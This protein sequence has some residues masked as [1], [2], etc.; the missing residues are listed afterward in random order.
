[1]HCDTDAATAIFAANRANA[2]ARIRYTPGEPLSRLSD[3]AEWGGH[4]V[5]FPTPTDRAE[6]VLLNTGGGMAGGDALA[7]SVALEAGAELTFTTQS[8][9]RIYRSAGATS[10]IALDLEVGA[11]ADLAFIPQE[12]IVFSHACLARTITAEVAESATLLLAEALVFGRAA[13][14]ERVTGGSLRDRWRIRRGGKLVYAD[15]VR[16]EGP[17][18]ELLQRAAIG[19]GAGAVGCLLLVSPDAA[20]RLDFTRG[21]LGGAQC[22]VAASAWNG[23]L[24]VRAAGEP[25]ALRQILGRAISGLSQ[26]TLPRVWSL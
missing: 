20:D 25:A 5:K 23:L 14:G 19:D 2:G 22:R 21:L 3:L 26:R 24:V 16:L 9:E 15:D 18:S 13:S 17:M 4:R 12:T 8:A 6:A 10:T 11:G 1:M 7:V